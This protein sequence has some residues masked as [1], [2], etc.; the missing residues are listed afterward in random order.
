MIGFGTLKNGYPAFLYEIKG[1]RIR[2]LITDFGATVVSLFV[3]MPDGKERDVVLGYDNAASYENGDSF[4]GAVVGR[5]A[6]RVANARFK[7]GGK[8]YH[9]EQND[10]V[11]TLHSG[12]LPYSK[13]LWKT[14]GPTMGKDQI[15]FALTSPD[16]DQ[17]FPGE[18]SLTVTYTITED[19]AL[20]METH[21]VSDS[22]TVVNIT[23]HSYFNLKGHDGGSVLD[24][25]LKIEAD[26]YTPCD[27]DLTVTGEIRPLDGTVF[28]FRNAKLIGTDIDSDC[29]ELK[30][31]GGYDLNYAVRGY[32][33]TIRLAATA[34]TQNGIS[35]ELLTNMP[36][37]LLY[38]GNNLSNVR[39]KDGTIY[40][41]RS[42]FCLEA[43]YF[44]NAINEP[45]F[46][47]P[48]LKKGDT[49]YSYIK[50]RFSV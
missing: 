18:L 23:N 1:K 27:A 33:G 46:L 49:Y 22:D 47:S 28:D 17:G 43:E 30:A 14:E 40:A 20:L 13:R 9:L 2:A 5:Y 45:L 25:S 36:G 12:S 31:A 35:M 34:A 4:L 10:G 48:I 19:D 37:V 32:D 42:G 15:T 39:G 11:H 26:S 21:A 6:D 41:P 3:R 16:G 50:Y 44:P 29:S 38:T 8:T 24:H 7:L